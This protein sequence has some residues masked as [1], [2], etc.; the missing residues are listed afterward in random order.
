MF[1]RPFSQHTPKLFTSL[2]IACLATNI[3]ISESACAA[4]HIEIVRDVLFER[5]VAISPQA[6]TSTPD[7]GF[8]IVG[9]I[10]VAQAWAIRIDSNMHVMWRQTLE[11]PDPAPGI[12]ASVYTGAVVLHDNSVLLCG[13]LDT[14]LHKKLVG[15][16]TRVGSRGEVIDQSQVIPMNDELFKSG[17]L[18]GC[19]A[20]NDGIAVVGNA[21]RFEGIG[22]PTPT[23]TH[24]LWYLEVDRSGVLMS[25]KVTPVGDNTD[26]KPQF[27]ITTN[28]DVAVSVFKGNVLLDHEGIL[29]QWRVGNPNFILQNTTPQRMIQ[30]ISESGKAAVTT[31]DSNFREVA[32]TKGVPMGMFATRAYATPNGIAVFGYR[33][34]QNGATTAAIGWLR[35]DLSANEVYTFDP[36]SSSPE[37]RGATPTGVAGEFAFVRLILPQTQLFGPDENRIG[38]LL[39]FV[40]YR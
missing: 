7:G 28:G 9:T 10:G 15:V 13:W 40:R 35:S 24:Y 22:S 23:M 4:S 8:V 39:T 18:L 16:L 26:P 36:I 31:L 12:G 19:A 6:I 14:G 37:V 21:T 20:S 34:D 32:T 3:A 1:S 25:Q 2:L 11:H 33:A 27:S 29:K 38:L 5:G 30:M 17:Y